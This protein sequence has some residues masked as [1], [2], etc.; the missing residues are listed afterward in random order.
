[1]T[2]SALH[3]GNG[4]RSFL[5]PPLDAVH[6]GP[7]ALDVLGSVLA[8]LGLARVFLVTSPSVHRLLVERG[9]PAL[10]GSVS[11]S[12]FSAVRPHAPA[13]SVMEAV[14]AAM[15]WRPDCVLS[16]GG[17][18][19]IDTAKAVAMAVPNAL[20]SWEAFLAYRID[21]R[22]ERPRLPNEPLCHLSVPTTLGSSEFTHSFTVTDPASGA[23]A[24]FWDER[25]AP[26]HAIIDPALTTATPGWL[27]AAGGMKTL[28]HSVEWFLSAGRTSFTD[29]LCLGAWKLLWTYL[30]EACSDGSNGVARLRCHE[31]AWMSAYGALNVVGGLSHAIGHHLGPATGIAHGYTASIVLPRAVEFNES[32]TRERQRELLAAVPD[33]AWA[34]EERA[35]SLADALRSM[36][37]RLGLPQTL[38]EA[39]AAPIDVRAVAQ[40]AMT[41]P[42]LRNNPKPVEASDIERLLEA[43]R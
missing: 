37:R 32:H 20:S 12:V 36:A 16:V 28:D 4:H 38:T 27:W 39:E 6:F 10:P 7:G 43:A 35:T 5:M 1:M 18:S 21:G 26:R 31:A 14:E 23:K 11:M 41:D 34:H 29:A 9:L 24:M 40:A 17:G 15:V 33:G 22:D 30:P 8:D 25:L 13:E 42:M 2:Q 3:H 19:V